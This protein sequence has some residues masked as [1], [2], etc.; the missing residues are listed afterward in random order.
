MSAKEASLHPLVACARGAETLR[1]WSVIVTIFGDAV[2]PRGG[3]ISGPALAELTAPLGIGGGALRVALHRLVRDG[4]LERRREGRPSR[5]ALS[6]RGLAEFAPA[7][8]RIYAAGPAGE[9]NLTLWL[10]EP[11]LAAPRRAELEREMAGR[12]A[13]ALG[14]GLWLEQGANEAVSAELFGFH[15]AAG[16][17]PGWLRARLAPEELIAAYRALGDD[18]EALG[19]RLERAR[20]EGALAAALRVLVVHRWR[21]CLLRH[22]DL[23]VRFFPEDWPGEA[24]RAQFLAL[25][26][27]L[28]VAA[29]PWL[30]ALIGPALQPL[31]LSK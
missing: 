9:E 17:P 11:G 22:P 20:P 28:S 24:V 23:P 1:V 30:D 29:D 16:T 5:Y 18:L 2:A 21:R 10:A 14:P 8:A 27:R 15:G 25:H 13:V 7:A 12:G 26:R 4:W 19:R 31:R 6:A 3:E